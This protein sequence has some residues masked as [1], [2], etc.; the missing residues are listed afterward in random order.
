[1]AS[2]AVNDLV[3]EE[4]KNGILPERIVSNVIS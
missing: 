2:I 3:E 4:I 1:M